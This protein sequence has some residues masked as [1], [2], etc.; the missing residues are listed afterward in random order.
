MNESIHGEGSASEPQDRVTDLIEQQSAISEV[1]RTI[2]SSPHDLQPVF[3]AILD[4][5]TRLCRAD[6]GTL[7]L[8]EESGLTS[9]SRP[10]KVRGQPL[11][12]RR[13]EQARRCL[14]PRDEVSPSHRSSSRFVGS[15]AR[16][17]RG[18]VGKDHVE[19]IK[20]RRCLLWCMSPNGPSVH[21]LQCRDSNRSDHRAGSPPWRTVL[22]PFGIRA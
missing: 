7:R 18:C 6:I 9:K 20:E 10:E 1:L 17:G 13:K 8:S 2:A 15:A 22:R 16:P 19:L 3:D 14:K 21:S 5:A 4:S 11:C 12:E